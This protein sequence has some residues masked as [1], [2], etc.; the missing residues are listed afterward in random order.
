ML[1]F[2]GDGRMVSKPQHGIGYKGCE[3]NMARRHKYSLREMVTNDTVRIMMEKGYAYSDKP[4]IREISNSVIDTILRRGEA[5][6]S[7]ANRLDQD[8]TVKQVQRE[9]RKAESFQVLGSDFY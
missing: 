3:I 9:L 4:A 5:S 2:I 7:Q 1:K 6:E 8:V